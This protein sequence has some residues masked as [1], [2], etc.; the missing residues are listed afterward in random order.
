MVEELWV[1]MVDMYIYKNGFDFWG[2]GW[3]GLWGCGMMVMLCVSFFIMWNLKCR[4]GKLLLIGNLS[5]NMWR[6]L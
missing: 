1:W 5:L 4:V 2:Y 6:K 3:N